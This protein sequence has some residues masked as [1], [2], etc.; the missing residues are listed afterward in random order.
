MTAP[1]FTR[2]ASAPR[3]VLMREVEGEAVLLNL[4]NGRYYGLDPVGT[5]M[6][7]VLTSTASVE[8]ACSQLEGE[9]DVTPDVL[10]KDVAG[11]VTRLTEQG[12]LELCDA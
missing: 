10:R 9:Y 11:F 7:A 5:R 1:L 2:R 3:D 12:L 8:A 4:D 6:W